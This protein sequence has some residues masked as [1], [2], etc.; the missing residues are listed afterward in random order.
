MPVGAL[1]LTITL[2]TTSFSRSTYLDCSVFTVTRPSVQS[3]LIVIPA[4]LHFIVSFSLLGGISSSI[5]W[6][7]SIATLG[8]WFNTNRDLGTGLATTAGGFGGVLYPMMF[9][10]L[11]HQIGFEWTM[12]CFALLS[13]CC[14]AAG[15][16]LLK[17]RLPRTMRNGILLDW[18]GFRD[19]RF[20]VT[21]AAIFVLDGAVLVPPSYIT[22]YANSQSL[23]GMSPHILAILNAA[24]IFGRGLPGPVADRIGRFNV[25]VL[26][27]FACTIST[28]GLWLG[29][30][31]STAGLISF[32]L[33]YGFFSGSAYS[34]TPVCV[35]QLCKT[36]DY[37]SR[38]GTA[39]GIVSL[40]TLA[41]V[42]LSGSILGTGT[43]ENY[44]AL[45]VFCGATYAIATV[46]LVIARVVS[47][48][49]RLN[50]KF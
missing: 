37:A 4:Y 49:W 34:L 45:I 23:H 27:S 2:V 11:V 31:S 19:P 21:M 43:G 7:T 10:R 38:Y 28:F 8:H 40:A 13:G 39:Y 25:M 1:G 47:K 46:L 6:T 17:T 26:C 48:G 14:L 32:S 18:K 35:A 9:A 44:H 5:R 41:G 3:L 15:I 50:V 12:R 42:P 33:L 20:D 22:M 24:S 16:M 29:V 36:E 30:G